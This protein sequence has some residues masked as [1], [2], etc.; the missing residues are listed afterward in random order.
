VGIITNIITLKGMGILAD[1]DARSPSLEFRRYNLVYGF[2]GSGKSTLSRLFSS[3]QVGALDPKLPEGAKFT[4]ALNDGSTIEF[5]NNLHV[6]ESRL[7]VFNTDY[8][9]QNLHW[10]LGRAKPV[11]YIGKDQAQAAAQLQVIEDEIGSLKAQLVVLDKDA[12]STEKQFNSF[13]TQ[14]ARQ[15]ATCIGAVGRAYEATHFD[16]DYENYKHDGLP[17][18]TDEQLRV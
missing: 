1:R 2:N 10:S 7:H 3:L 12:K 17:P 9:D 16:K 14:S 15:I 13:R 18:L 4:V 8:V 11:F 5:P 6:L